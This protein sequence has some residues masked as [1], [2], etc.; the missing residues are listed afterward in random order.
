MPSTVD[1]FRDAF[2]SHPAGVA[3]VAATVDGSPVGMTI[4]SLASLTLEPLALT[5]NVSRET[6]TQ[7]ALLRADG[8][9][10]HLLGTEHAELADNF[11]RPDGIR[12]SEEQGWDVLPTGEPYLPS[13]PYGLR[14]RVL[15]RIRVGSS[16]IVAAEVLSVL[17]GPRSDALIYHNRSFLGVSET[18]SVS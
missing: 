3:I 13:A 12:F 1:K 7:A 14:T 18:E 11:A 6:G 17:R 10:V 9:M 15:Q 16:T 2:R 8:F 5:F 4:S